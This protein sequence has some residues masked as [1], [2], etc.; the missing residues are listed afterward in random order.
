[1]RM[2]RRLQHTVDQ[3]CEFVAFPTS[4]Q[5]QH[6]LCQQQPT[7]T[8]KLHSK[9]CKVTEKSWRQEFQLVKVQLGRSESESK[10]KVG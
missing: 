4:H 3:T 10:L 6:N 7:L 5:M 2:Y 1:M 8:T 9:F